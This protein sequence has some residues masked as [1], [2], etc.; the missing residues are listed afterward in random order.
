MNTTTPTTPA[1]DTLSGPEAA[2]LIGVNPATLWRWTRDGHIPG[3]VAHAG[4][5]IYDR[6]EIEKFGATRIDRSGIRNRIKKAA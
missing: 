6:N 4:R 2:A 1:T 5:Y 3:V